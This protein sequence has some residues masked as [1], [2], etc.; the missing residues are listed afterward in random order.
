MKFIKRLFILVLFS[1]LFST[2]IHSASETCPG[3]NVN[4][5]EG[6]TT[7]ITETNANSGTNY[8][9]LTIPSDGTLSITFNNQDNKTSTFFVGTS[10]ASIN[11]I[12][13]GTTSSTTH[14]VLNITVQAGDTIQLLVDD[15][16][17]N[18]D[19]TI[20]TSYTIASNT[21]NVSIAPTTKSIF[22]GTSSVTLN[23]TLSEAANKDDISVTYEH[24][25]TGTTT[26]TIT[27]LQG[28]TTANLL[29]NTSAL[30]AGTSCVATLSN[31]VGSG[32]QLIGSI[33]QDT[34]TITVTAPPAVSVDLTIT[35]TDSADP[36]AVNDDF[37]YTIVVAN[38]GSD[39]ATNIIV[40]DTLPS[41]VTFRNTTGS[42]LVWSCSESDGNITCTHSG[43]IASGA[44][45]SITVNV[46]APSE[47]G[48]ITNEVNVTSDNEIDFTNNSTV[49]DT[50]IG[51]TD[52]PADLCYY[53]VLEDGNSCEIA[54]YFYYAPDNPHACVTSQD[55]LNQNTTDTLN[56]V[57]V[58][59]LYDYR[60]RVI[61]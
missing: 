51:D 19:Y 31:L 45:N 1:F 16:G 7:S 34:S 10:C 8:H 47:G 29:I 46:T 37:Y 5:V 6:T 49:E 39:D 56:N 58:Y 42:D 52:N 25:C 32:D 28:N 61:S 9:Q 3:D 4:I 17:K 53:N 30:I 27:F 24:N 59:K 15:T 38:N 18:E 60:V 44:S 22:E 12:Y 54:G 50:T 48:T 33:T 40:T 21:P 35:K 26:G 2:Q 11:D 55:I 36:V 23:V 13:N 14:T 43:T 20:E 57:I 41:G